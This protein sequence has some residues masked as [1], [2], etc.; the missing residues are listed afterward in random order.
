MGSEILAGDIECD[1]YDTGGYAH[2]NL[3]KMFIF[4]S[5]LRS[6]VSRNILCMYLIP[7]LCPYSS[8]SF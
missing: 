7:E 8:K 1:V 2:F 6:R 4:S 5:S 3:Q